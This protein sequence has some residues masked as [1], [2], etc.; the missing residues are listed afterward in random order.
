MMP[1]P[2]ERGM[3]EIPEEIRTCVYCRELIRFRSGWMISDW[4]E[5]LDELPPGVALPMECPARPKPGMGAGSF[6]Q[7][8]PFGEPAARPRGEILAPC[9]PTK[10]P[11]AIIQGEVIEG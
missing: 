6:F 11:P 1:W 5:I 8:T 9:P 4:W 7:H 2:L 10:Q 3:P